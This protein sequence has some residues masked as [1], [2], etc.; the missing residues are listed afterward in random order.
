MKI[1]SDFTLGIRVS[2]GTTYEWSKLLLAR[3]TFNGRL[4]LLTA[5][6][7]RALGY[8][9]EEFMGKTLCQLMGSNKSAA[10]GAVAAILDERNTAPVD[11]TL[12]RR[13][14]TAERLRFY[15]RLDG[16]MREVFIVA[17]DTCHELAQR[18]RPYRA[19]GTLK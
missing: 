7:G 3:A 10:A 8:S 9:A 5:A 12:R 13:D 2:H 15:R 4:E 11:L 14:G 16:Y 19:S 17:E 1:P 6:W 18:R